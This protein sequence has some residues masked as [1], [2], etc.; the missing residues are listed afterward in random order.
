M[1]SKKSIS[2]ILMLAPVVIV[3]LAGAMKFVDLAPFGAALREYPLI[4]EWSIPSLVFLV[5][6]LELL[7]LMIVVATGRLRVASIV[8]AGLLGIFT[9]FVAVNLVT[10]EAPDCACFGLLAE[11]AVFRADAEAALLRNAVLLGSAVVGLFL[12]GGVNARC[13]APCDRS[14]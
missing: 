6:L 14:S 10:M 3:G 4:P 13:A 11:F 7:T 8:A 1:V 12:Y 5:P 9:I 2:T